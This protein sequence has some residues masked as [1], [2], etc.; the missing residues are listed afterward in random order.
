MEV[1]ERVSLVG[2]QVNQAEGPLVAATQEWRAR[3]SLPSSVAMGKSRRLR[4]AVRLTTRR[5]AA[6]P[7]GAKRSRVVAVVEQPSQV[8]EVPVRRTQVEG[9]GVE[10][11]SHWVEVP[12]VALTPEEHAREYLTTS[13][14][15]ERSRR[16]L[17]AVA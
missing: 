13:V 7:S 14:A 4:I 8:V 9:P 3:M 17:T 11:V 5:S 16:R 12:L 15:M 2:E 10:R 1:V 6:A